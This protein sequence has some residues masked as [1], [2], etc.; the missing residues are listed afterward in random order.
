MQRQLLNKVS[1]FLLVF[2]FSVFTILPLFK[3][4]FFP[5]HDDTQVARVNQMAIV[6]SEGIF[7][8]R[9]VPDLG[10][11]Y[12]YP[13]F[14]F[15]APFAYYVGGFFDVIGF[16]SLTATKI[17]IGLGTLCAAFSMYLLAKEFW[18][19]SGAIVSALLYVYAP[20]HAINIYVR[21]A[22]GELWG[23]GLVPFVFWGLY[24]IYKLLYLEKTSQLRNRR[25]WLSVCITAMS[26]GLVIISHNLTAFMIT[27]FLF[28]F[29][30][31][32]FI[33]LTSRR[34]RNALFL[35]V[36][37][38]LGIMVS[39]FYWLPATVE[40]KY[41]N[42]LSVVGGGSDYKDHFVCV[43]QL[44]ASPWGYGGSAPGCM[45]GM[46]FKIGKVGLI[47][48][49]LSLLSVFFIRGKEKRYALVLGVI[50]AILSVFLLL[51]YSK[52]VWDLL[53]QMA[54]FQFPWRFL[55]LVVFF[56]SFVGGAIISIFPKYIKYIFVAI[57]VISIIV[58]YKNIFVPSHITTKTSE[59]YVDKREIWWNTSKISDE[60][61]PRSFAKPK[62]EK[63]ISDKK[64][65]FNTPDVDHRTVRDTSYIHSVAINAKEHSLALLPIAYF[66]AW[67]VY[68]DEKE[69]SYTVLNRG[70]LVSVP[71]GK[72]TLTAEFEQTPIEVFANNVSLTGVL[73]MVIGIIY[74][75]SRHYEHK[76]ANR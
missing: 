50:G 16:D 8:V 60:Y 68:I 34:K 2:L 33:L 64:I 6:L 30:L 26:Y 38:L 59:A 11:G 1:G 76:K 75:Q 20:Y 31:F 43:S 21:G 46:S 49:V 13:I 65:M 41:T 57:C 72:H 24:R 70:L 32:L 19:K 18:G 28:T 17:M 14:N 61:M 54:F 27:P 63:K 4:G 45:D 71:Q 29:A 23:Y 62:S 47:I 56:L 7:P 5:I 53:P 42:V 66:P 67:K 37:L 22:V 39:A 36:S 15:Y 25:L 55:L 35:F 58:S 74:L 73:I 52:F 51:D 10:Y 3:D 12:G 48:A 9:W 40:M 69:V 44:I